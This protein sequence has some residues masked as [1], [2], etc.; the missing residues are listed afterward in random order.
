MRAADPYPVNEYLDDIFALI[1]KPLNGSDAVQNN[2]RRQQQRTYVDLLGSVLNPTK[3]K[4]SGYDIKYL[5]SDVMLYAE[6]HL[7][8]LESWLKAQP[9]DAHN[10]NLLLRINN[11]RNKYEGRNN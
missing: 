1:W 2:Y 5:R 9:S 3:D 6:Q 8:K 10:K 11:I 4:E 7:D